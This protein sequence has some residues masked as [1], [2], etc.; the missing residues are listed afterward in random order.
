MLIYIVTTL[1]QHWYFEFTGKITR[2]DADKALKLNQL[3]QPA[4]LPAPSFA[5]HSNIDRTSRRNHACHID[6]PPRRVKFTKEEQK[7]RV[8]ELECETHKSIE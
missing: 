4:L 2:P 5:S 6:L 3:R 1:Q 8:N 7:K